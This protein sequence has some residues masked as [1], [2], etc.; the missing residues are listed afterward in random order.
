MTRLHSRR[1]A[2]QLL[3]LRLLP[4]SWLP[5]PRGRPASGGGRP[6]AFVASAAERPGLPVLRRRRGRLGGA[7]PDLPA[8]VVAAKDSLAEPRSC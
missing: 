6:G 1:D 3:D 5:R 8:H 7:G 4:A 2:V